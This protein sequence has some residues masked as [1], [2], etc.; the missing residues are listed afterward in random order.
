M[1]FFNDKSDCI[2]FK[3]FDVPV[4]ILSD[5][6][7]MHSL[8]NTCVSVFGDWINKVDYFYEMVVWMNWAIAQSCDALAGSLLHTRGPFYYMIN[9]GPSMDE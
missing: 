7:R 9:F 4:Y 5:M 8:Y 6:I 3:C 1:I 2:I